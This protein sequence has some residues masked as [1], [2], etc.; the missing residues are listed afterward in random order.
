M[1]DRLPNFD[2]VYFKYPWISRFRIPIISAHGI[3]GCISL[4]VAEIR[5]AASP[6]TSSDF[7]TAF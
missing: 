6:M 4:V 3:P 1:L 5:R 7:R 2:Q